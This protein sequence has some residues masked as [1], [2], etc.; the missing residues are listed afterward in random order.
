M[1]VRTYLGAAIAAFL[2]V[3]GSAG[4]SSAATSTTTPS[5]L[6]TTPPENFSCGAAQKTSKTGASYNALHIMI[7]GNDVTHM[8]TSGS[9]V[10]VTFNAVTKAADYIVWSIA[11]YMGGVKASGSI[12]VPAGQTTANVSCTSTRAGYFAVSAKLRTSGATQ[13][14]TGSRPAGYATFGVLPNVADYVPQYSSSLDTRRFGMTGSSYVEPGTGLQPLNENLGATWVMVGRSMATT[15]P[16]YAGQYNPNTYPTDPSIKLGTLARIIDIAGLPRW[17][18]TEPRTATKGT[19]PPKSFSAYQNYV[20]LVGEE[21][22]RLHSEYIPNQHKNY[23][24]VTWETNPGPP[25]EWMGTDSQMVELYQAAHAGAHSTDPDAMV[26]GPAASSVLRCIAW[27]EQ[28]APYGWANY[29]DAVSC[30]GYY[31]VASSSSK[32]PEPYGLPGQIRQLRAA[33]AAAHVKAGTKLFMTETGISYPMGSVYAS[34]YPTN[35][36]LVE[37]AE[38]V[39]R[40][41]LIMLGEGVD[42]TF[43]F[44]AADYTHEVGFGMYFNLS[45]P[46]HDVASTSIAPKPATMAIAAAT[47]LVDGSRS[48]GALTN[49]PTDGYGYAF[50]LAG[51]THAMMAVWAHNSSFNA[52]EPY[53]VQVDAPGTSGKTMMFDSMGNP[54]S[55][56]Y[57]NGMV[58]VTLGEMPLY[59]LSSHVA[60]ASSHVRVPQGYDTSF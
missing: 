18:S 54:Q 20:A 22:A 42:T 58:T 45:M 57:T 21:S 25:T 41:H 3:W 13:P 39:V 60:A 30:H 12:S 9:K 15:E 8:Y 55:V 32:P 47:R 19:Y 6:T 5:L 27:I 36:V 14:Q 43:P 17:A 56:N 23:Y 7:E 40:T 44:Y 28:M 24:Q 59:V 1:P 53:S 48:L 11:G 49:M 10:T 51:S 52:S 46:V 16:D 35:Q 37:H 50:R 31:T 38:A 34:N 33:M 26:M 2:T 4:E 29:V